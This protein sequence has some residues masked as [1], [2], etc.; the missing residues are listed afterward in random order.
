MTPSPDPPAELLSAFAHAMSLAP[1]ARRGWLDEL[2]ARA[3][4]LCRDLE[5]LLAAHDDAGTFLDEP[6]IP[7]SPALDEPAVAAV[8]PA[9][10]GAPADDPW[11]GRMLGAYRLTRRIGTGGTSVVYGAER[12]DRQFDKRVA[13]KLLQHERDDTSLAGRLRA[14]RQVLATLEHPHIA[15]LLDGGETPDG[16]PY[17]VMEYVDGDAIDRHCDAARL[18]LEARL[19]LFRDV[20]EAVDYAHA[21]QV[22]HRDLKPSNILVTDAGVV[23]LLDFGIAKLLQGSANR[24]ATAAAMM[25]PHYASPEQLRG[26]AITPATDVYSLGVLLYQLVT[27][28][29]PHVWREGGVVRW[30]EEVLNVAPTLPSRAIETSTARD[31]AARSMEPRT[32]MRRVRG[33][34]DRILMKALE[35]EP[36]RRYS[37]PRALAVDI[38]CF[39][40]NRPV[41]ARP[42]T[43][44]YRAA[45]WIRRNR[46]LAGAIAV[47]VLAIGGATTLTTNQFLG[48]TSV[49]V[50]GGATIA[51]TALY[52]RA[53]RLRRRAQEYRRVSEFE[54]RKS[55]EI[56]RFLKE[57]LRSISPDVARGQDTTLMRSLLE[58]SARRIETE[59]VDQ[60]DVAADMHVTLGSAYVSLAALDE[61]H[62]HLERAGELIGPESH[63]ELWKELQIERTERL[64]IASH[65]DDAV[66]VIDHAVS[67]GMPGEPRRKVRLLQ[68]RA[69]A[70]ELAGRVSEAEVAHREALAAAA[71]ELEP[72][73]P[74][75]AKGWLNLG[76]FCRES[77]SLE[78]AEKAIRE[79]V[80]LARLAGGD[81]TDALHAIN[82]LARLLA[83][84]REHEEAESLYRE[85]LEKAERILG[86]DH[87]HYVHYLIG[88]ATLHE[89]RGE[90]DEAE[91]LHTRALETQRATLG[92]DHVDVATS[93][94]NLAFMYLK[95]ERFADSDR[96]YREATETYQRALGP[97][98]PWV[99]MTRQ[100]HAWAVVGVGDAAR[101]RAMVEEVL[102]SP[103]MDDMR[104]KSGF[105]VATNRYVLGMALIDLGETEEGARLVRENR[106]PIESKFEPVEVFV[107]MGRERLA[108]VEEIE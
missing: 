87:P 27:G 29:L 91:R 100:N 4:E 25:T 77:R 19:R 81:G 12:A 105:F 66:R 20:C 93:L 17:I 54:R 106:E 73:D 97:D 47:V 67:V 65:Y 79:A 8:P 71:R 14:E 75:V 28:Q 101:A 10:T 95:M 63:P 74:L 60:P 9:G 41:S 52:L 35:K 44:V 13:V 43:P 98:H 58:S 32:L 5:S 38:E 33:D 26:H 42:S 82:A 53:E 18:S 55:E 92:P 7:R 56:S 37:S 2:R 21:H 59:F 69:R 64:L 50:L 34:L 16:M 24:T 103:S 90:W 89:G 83:R 49:A 86:V 40:E 78:E 22:V 84:R 45:K 1:G 104:R 57:M 72:E 11:V 15:R 23:K 46:T 6:V 108:R 39:L 51:V 94:N 48:A 80:R 68:A 76:S 88:L 31:I 70:L 62:A 3:P 96:F 102:S 107:K 99:M 61:A 36:A 30:I 85:V